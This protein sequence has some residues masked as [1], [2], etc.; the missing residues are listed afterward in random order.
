M[1][2]FSKYKIIHNGYKIDWLDSMNEV[3]SYMETEVSKHPGLSVK[4]IMDRT[5]KLSGNTKLRIVRYQY[6]TLY[7]EVFL[8]EYEG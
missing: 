4:K 2:T 1:R 6:R 3:E 7:E 8:I 5:L